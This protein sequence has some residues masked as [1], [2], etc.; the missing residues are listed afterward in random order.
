M[1]IGGI[2]RD[3]G[4]TH[5][6]KVDGS[7]VEETT[8]APGLEVT[9]GPAVL[10]FQLAAASAADVAAKMG[11]EAAVSSAGRLGHRRAVSA[12]SVKPGHRGGHGCCTNADVH[13]ASGPASRTAAATSSSEIPS[14]SETIAAEHA[15]TDFGAFTLEHG[16]VVRLIVL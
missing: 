11:S 4:S 9:I 14:C 12:R 5:G 13:A 3:L 7:R 6:V 2:V 16:D 10:K 1:T 15:D 8:S